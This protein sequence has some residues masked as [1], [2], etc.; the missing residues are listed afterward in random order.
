MLPENNVGE[1]TICLQCLTHADFVIHMTRI[2]FRP[3]SD[4]VEIIGRAVRETG[5]SPSEICRLSLFE[6]LRKVNPNKIIDASTERRFRVLK[7]RRAAK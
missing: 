4:L 7:Q 6:W 3:D 2:T 5:L 1:C